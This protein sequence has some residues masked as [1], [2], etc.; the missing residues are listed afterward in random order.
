[1][2]EPTQAWGT[3]RPTIHRRRTHEKALFH[4]PLSAAAAARSA[5][6]IAL[7]KS[8]LPTACVRTMIR[9]GWDYTT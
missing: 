4:V 9:R 1:M 5:K 2:E 7:W 6:N 3:V 8:Y